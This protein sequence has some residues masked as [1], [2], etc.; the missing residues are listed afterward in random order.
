MRGLRGLRALG[1]LRPLGPR[2]LLGLLGPLRLLGLLGLSVWGIWGCSADSETDERG[3]QP[4]QDVPISFSGQSQEGRTVT[5]APLKDE[6]TTFTVYGFK[7]TDASPYTTYQTVFPGYRVLWKE[8]SAATSTTNTE[9]WEYV[10]QQIPGGLEQTVKYWDYGAYAYR[11]MAVTGSNVSGALVTNEGTTAYKLTFTADGENVA[12]TPY[13]SHLWFSE[14]SDPKIGRPVELQFLKP[15]CKVRFSFIFEDPTVAPTTVLSDK[16]FKPTDGTTIQYWGNVFVS[17]PLT[18]TAT[19]ETLTI[20]PEGT[21]YTAF[22]QEYYETKMEEGNKVYPYQ[23]GNDIP[24]PEMKWY[25]VL[26]AS[27]QG[28]YTLTVSVDGDPKTTVVPAEFMNWQP[29]YE[30][31]YVFKVHVDGGV[32]IDNVQSAFTQWEEETASRT[33]YNW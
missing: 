25:T 13:Y 3:L 32:A 18:G 29:G 12:N 27:N 22:T 21:S 6:T 5:R 4:E 14:I 2:G 30:Y 24:G 31:T 26:P 11:F 16:S 19:T 15:L 17:Y 7:N 28:T 9:G 23:F 33:V 8:N 1:R 10:N 20:D